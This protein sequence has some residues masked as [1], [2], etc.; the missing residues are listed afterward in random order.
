MST[1]PL[2]ILFHV[3]YPH[4]LYRPTSCFCI[5]F[6]NQKVG[7]PRRTIFS[8]GR[9]D[10]KPA[11]FFSAIPASPPVIPAQPEA[12]FNSMEPSSIL[13]PRLREDYP[14]QVCRKI[15]ANTLSTLPQFLL[16]SFPPSLVN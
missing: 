4:H 9:P 14:K 5:Y 2:N 7:A 12:T 10:Y 3:L 8:E 6:Q 15:W 13:I 1:P 16:G 11:I